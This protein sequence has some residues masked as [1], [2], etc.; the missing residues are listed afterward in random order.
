[1]NSKDKSEKQKSKKKN[2]FRYFWFDFIKITGAISV[3][4]WLR[5]KLLYESKKAKKK[6]RGGA[7]VIANHLTWYDIL[8][9][10]ATIWYRHVHMAAL[11][12]LF[13]PKMGKW[14][15]TRVLCIPVDRENFSLSSYRAMTEVLKSGG[16][17]GIFP[18]GR[19]NTEDKTTVNSFKAGAV[20]LALRTHVPIVPLYLVPPKKWYNR[21]VTVTGEPINLDEFVAQGVDVRNTETISQMVRERELKLIEFYNDWKGKKSKKRK[22][23]RDDGADESKAE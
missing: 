18:E 13:E 8:S 15:F 10:F 12:D 20:Q 6:I 5:P 23:E 7:V 4:V 1:M 2:P 22:T 3:L 14:F 9:I 19:I 17:L 16:I 21:L 11:K